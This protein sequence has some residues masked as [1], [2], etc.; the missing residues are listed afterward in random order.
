MLQMLLKSAREIG[1][2]GAGKRSFHRARNT[3]DAPSIRGGSSILSM[4][5]AGHRKALLGSGFLSRWAVVVTKPLQQRTHVGVEHG[6][7]IER[8]DLAKDESA[9]DT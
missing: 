2:F 6:R 5:R 7:D 9:Y 4:L 8:D 1:E 3:F